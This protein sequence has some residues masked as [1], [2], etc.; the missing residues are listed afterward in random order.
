VS[1]SLD[2]VIRVWDLDQLKCLNTISTNPVES[3]SVKFSP[4][5]KY[6][7]TG[8]HSGKITTYETLPAGT[9]R[10]EDD[11]ALTGLVDTINTKGKFLFNVVYSPNGKLMAAGSLEGIIYVID[12]ETRKILTSISGWFYSYL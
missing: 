2:S 10:G 9:P 6:F 11:D 1:N 4:D 3:W 8:S 12:V 5:G 7:T